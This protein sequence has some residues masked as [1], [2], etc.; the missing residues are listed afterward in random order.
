MNTDFLP[1]LL[2]DFYKV[3]HPDQYPEGTEVVYST[4]TPRR[5]MIDGV[6]HIVFFGLQG[7]IKEWLIEFY[8][9]HFFKK[10]RRQVIREYQRVIYYTLINPGNIQGLSEDEQAAGLA[11]VNF[12]R[13]E[14]LWEIGYLPIRIKALKEG[15]LVPIRVPACTIENTQ[16]P[17]YWVTNSLETLFSAENWQ[18]TTD[19]TI[20]FEYRKIL[21]QYAEETGDPTFVPFQGHDFGMRGMAGVHAAARCDAG[22]L[23]SFIGTDTIPGILYH[24]KYYNADIAKE[25]VGTSIPATEH[26]VMC[27]NGQDEYAVIKR[28]LT[29]VYP[30]GF[31]SNVSDTW[32][33]WHL[34]VNVYP[35][36]K[37]EI[38]ARDG[39]IVIRPDSGDPVKIVCG[40]FFADTPWEQKGL[41]ECLWDTFGGTTNE[42]GYKVLDPHVGVIYGDSITLA[43]AKAICIRLKSK[44]FASTNIVFG[45]GSYT[46]QYNT[47]DTFGFA[48]KSTYCVV[49][50]EERLIYKDP[51]TDDGMKK[52]QKGLVVVVEEDGELKCLDGM[53]REAHGEVIGD[54]LEDVFVDGELV[55][56]EKLSDIRTRL[57]SNL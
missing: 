26:S 7:F 44:G 39:R 3:S 29:E 31:F 24:E 11:M 50:G 4:W 33:F 8:N 2:C 57:L 19:A 28:M 30:N 9:T 54:L 21:T 41:I 35:A 40:D 18:P 53:N 56:D 55:R 47:R 43:R 17:F 36:L 5:S 20:A 32:D 25:V 49:K 22:H 51:K 15:T 12:S 34:V 10:S 6:D 45:I 42:K 14:A 48:I 1:T 23:L 27:A 46:Y 37:P 38:M 52:S 16:D 13:I